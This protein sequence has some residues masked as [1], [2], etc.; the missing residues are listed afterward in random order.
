MVECERIVVRA[1][2]TSH[3]VASFRAS[4]LPEDFYTIKA[5]IEKRK[6]TGIKDD[7]SRQATQDLLKGMKF[8]DL[9]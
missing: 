8:I 7:P 1:F 4:K 6:A 3:E 2:L 9:Y 5:E